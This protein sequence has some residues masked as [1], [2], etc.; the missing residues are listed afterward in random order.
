MKI[1]RQKI[2]AA[3]I[4]FAVLFSI[5]P[6]T[7]KAA[8][9]VF[10]TNPI[11]VGHQTLLQSIT[12][13]AT[14]ASK[15][16]RFFEWAFKAATEALK[17]QLLNMIVD[18]TVNWIQ[19][20]G[21]PKFIT[22]WPGFFRDAV[23]QAGGRFLQQLG[24]GQLCSPFSLQ[25]RAAFIPI[26]TFTERS[27]CTMSQ[28]GANLQSFLDNFQNGGWIAWNQMVLQP[29][30]N[31]YGAYMMAW[32]EGE[33]EKDAAAQAAA[34]EA[35]AG[36]GFL[37]VKGA[38]AERNYQGYQDCIKAGNSAADCDKASCIRYGTVTP[39][40]V[41]GDLAGKV[42]GSDIDYIVNAKDFAAYVSAITNAILDRVFK[43]GM[44]LLH[45]AL[46]SSSNSSGG[47]GSGGVASAQIQCGQLAGTAA[48][49]ACVSAVQTGTDIREFQK[50]NLIATLDQ[51]LSYQNQLLG[52]KQS[53]LAVLNQTIDIL[54]Q[55]KDCQASSS[56]SSA[57]STAAT[58]S[59]TRLA[60]LSITNDIQNIQSDI[61]ALQTKEQEIKAI[62]DVSQ[63]PSIWAQVANTVNP[64]STYSLALAAQDETSQKQQ[65]MSSYQSQL[66]VCQQSITGL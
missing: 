42:V 53:T 37:D 22:D 14:T 66:M 34:A 60:A 50:D 30:N 3:L 17:R 25:L 31:I 57:A 35:Q 7:V 39:G 6:P 41:V 19:G 4:F 40:A 38:C 5:K 61:I 45:S 33:I 24:L 18:Q 59:Q 9:P 56:P 26:P 20:G 52:A 8:V 21:N 63:I 64:A 1:S 36:K 49:N 28:V 10:E 46:S 23:D 13:F 65:A 29:Q 43:E 58:L 16:Q 55:L 12:S 54:N 62:T 48:Y 15:T 2:A 32:D 27:S 47:G 44:G 11:L 51:D